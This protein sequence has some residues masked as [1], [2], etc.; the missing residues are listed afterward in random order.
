VEKSEE[1]SVAQLRWQCRRGMRELDDL[2]VRYLETTYSSTDATEKAAF[3]SLL[4]LPDPDLIS[5][6]LGQQVP[7]PDLHSVTKRIRR[8]SET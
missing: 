4:T 2:L 1:Q 5:Y 8:D 3:R 6:L 7:P